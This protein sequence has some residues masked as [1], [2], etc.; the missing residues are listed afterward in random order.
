MPKLLSFTLLILALPLPAVA[1]TQTEYGFPITDTSYRDVPCHMVTRRGNTL[2][3]AKLCGGTP[4]VRTP[5][6]QSGLVFS[7]ISFRDPSEAQRSARGWAKLIDGTLTNRSNQPITARTVNYTISAI[8][9]G[10][11]EILTNNS[12]SLS[13]NYEPVTLM[14]GQSIRFTH[15]LDRTQVASMGNYIMQPDLFTFQVKNTSLEV[16][17]KSSIAEVESAEPERNSRSRRRS[18]QSY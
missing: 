2:D 7:N 18:R 6:A 5:Q 15:S 13:S 12:V 8:N 17:N 9:D 4:Q 3:L 10:R 1:Q 14:P 16:A 11:R